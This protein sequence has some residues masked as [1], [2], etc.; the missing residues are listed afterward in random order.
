MTG[1]NHFFFFSIYYAYICFVIYV[2]II[3]FILFHLFAFKNS[4][5]YILSHYFL[6]CLTVIC[7]F[8]CH[9]IWPFFSFFFCLF[10]FF[11]FSFIGLQQYCLIRLHEKFC[12][13]H[14]LLMSFAFCFSSLL[15]L[16]LVISV[17]III[18]AKSYFF[19]IQFPFSHFIEFFFV[20]WICAAMF[21][22]LLYIIAS[23]YL[24]LLHVDVKHM[25]QS[26]W[27]YDIIAIDAA[28]FYYWFRNGKKSKSKKRYLYPHILPHKFW[29]MGCDFEGDLNQSVSETREAKCG[30]IDSASYKVSKVTK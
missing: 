2:L 3:Y 1:D 26:N 21:F 16:C 23:G 20:L 19:V 22:L 11:F 8:A 9:Y 29:F 15:F 17:S 7:E 6:T 18:M 10:F 12:F 24:I 25:S 4:F 5:Y 13:V 28:E 30:D 14:F 27:I